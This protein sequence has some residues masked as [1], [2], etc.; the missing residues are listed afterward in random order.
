MN[1]K[2]HIKNWLSPYPRIRRFVRLVWLGRRPADLIRHLR[3]ERFRRDCYKRFQSGDH[4]VFRHFAGYECE[5]DAISP[6]NYWHLSI[7]SQ[8]E[9]SFMSRLFRDHVRHG[10]LV[11]DIGGHVG[12]WAVPLA[13]HVGPTGRVYVFEP[14]PEGYAAILRNAELNHLENITPLRLAL[15]DLSGTASF[16]I[17][18]DKDTHSLFEETLAPSPSGRQDVHTIEVSTV[19][20]LVDHK[21][22][23]PPNFVKIDVEGAELRVLDG[24]KRSAAGIDCLLVEIHAEELMLHGV[25][26][27]HAAVEKKV[28]TLGFPNHQ[29]VDAIHL[30][31]TR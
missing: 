26:D 13:K 21:V 23:A 24:M 20:D 1:L 9:D 8:H 14:E 15:S 12:M 28:V 3:D 29:Y 5:Y 10:M 16:Y 7:A 6:K 2:G 11:L 17:R 25:R 30:L 19:D 31:A 27:P 4:R 22:I 18:P